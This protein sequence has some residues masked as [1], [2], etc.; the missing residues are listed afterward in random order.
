LHISVL[1]LACSFVLCNSQLP[2]NIIENG[3]RCTAWGIHQNGVE[4]TLS[5]QEGDCN[6]PIGYEQAVAG[7]QV[8]LRFC[9][10]FSQPIPTAPQQ[11]GKQKIPP[12]TRI[13]GGDE[14]APHSW[15]WLISFQKNGNHFCGGTLIGP[16]HVLT[17]AHCILSDP[18]GLTIVAGLHDQ[19]QHVAGR[20]QRVQVQQIF[21]H[22][23][24]NTQTNQHD[25]AILKLASPVVLNDY[26][27]IA[28]LPSAGTEP[29]VKSPVMIAGW[30]TTSFQGTSPSRLL[31]A[32]VE[33]MKDCSMYNGFSDKSQICAGHPL[34]AKDSCQGDSGG[35]LMYEKNGQWHLSGAVSYG[36]GC[37][38][39]DFPG[40]YA[41]VSYYLPWIQQKMTL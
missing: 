16:R 24:Y 6:G 32:K 5:T 4:I 11:C 34:Y 19:K 1:L 22:E 28:C 35:P 2:L 12:V 17:A 13:V 40:V 18:Q 41:R 14:A 26:V 21:K 27:N 38:F 36:N 33:I 20:A 37:A 9:C 15:P 7:T 8:F 39:K 30:G 23:Q 29:A 31:Q 10:P 25:V 3:K